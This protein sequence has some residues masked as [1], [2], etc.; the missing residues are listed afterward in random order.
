MPTTPQLST[1]A[2]LG[3]LGESIGARP[4]IMA[5]TAEAVGGAI[6]PEIVGGITTAG[7]AIVGIFGTLW[8][9][10]IMTGGMISGK[11]PKIP[12]YNA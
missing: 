10:D 11:E 1:S 6:H 5:Q 3:H 4:E 7:I 8:G 2:E 12:F 9:L